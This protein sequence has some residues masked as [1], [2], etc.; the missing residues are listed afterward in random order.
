MKKRALSL[1]EIMIVIF[2]I[3]LVTGAVGY[4][5]KGA[6][7]KGKKFKTEQAMAQLE[8]LLLICLDENGLAKG[9]E[10]AADPGKYL[11]DSGLAKNPDKLTKDGW[12]EPFTIKYENGSFN[13]SSSHL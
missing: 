1:I 8:D 3:T 7:D 2:L 12:N 4:N 5:M 9:A 11:K 10:I 6:M 13:I